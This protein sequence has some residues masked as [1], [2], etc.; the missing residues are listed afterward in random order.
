MFNFE[1]VQR[2]LIVGA[3]GG[4]ISN[5]ECSISNLFKGY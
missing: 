3:A 2:I 5:F 4:E 1:F